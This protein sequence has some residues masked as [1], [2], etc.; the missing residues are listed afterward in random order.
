M[1]RLPSVVLI[2]KPNVGKSTFFNRFAGRVKSLVYD[3]P[4]VTRD[5]RTIETASGGFRFSLTDT[6]GSLVG[7]KD[8]LKRKVTELAMARVDAADCVLF[9]VDARSGWTE[10]DGAVWEVLRRTGKRVYLV[11]NKVDRSAAESLMGEFYET[12]HDRVFPVSSTQGRGVALLFERVR[13][14]LAHPNR[15]SEPDEENEAATRLAVLGRPNVGKS[16]LINRILREE[17]SVVFGSPGTT[18]DPV[19]SRH[20]HKGHAFRLVDT[21]GLRKRSRTVEDLEQMTGKA[22][23]DVI[24]RSD[25]VVVVL[26]ARECGVDQDVNLISLIVRKGRPLIV[27][28]NKADLVEDAER[29]EELKRKLEA[30]LHFAFK[31]PVVLVSALSGKRVGVL[32]DLARELHDKVKKRLRTSDLNRAVREVSRSGNLPSKGGR[33]LKVFFCRQLEGTPVAFLLNVNDTRLVSEVVKK[34]FRNQFIHFFRLEG[35]PL[36][37]IW[38]GR[39]KGRESGTRTPNRR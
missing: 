2:G 21:A 20:V 32:L 8:A 33:R 22:T 14:D 34:H 18:R 6:G 29:L 9:M 24:F 30:K 28:V 15:E 5:P 1:K 13:R 12:G 35:I 10:E 36:H 17:R 39:E 37:F 19:D 31:A 7:E 4:G 27:A 23:V 16:T 25:V 3:R 38:K 11:V 26:D